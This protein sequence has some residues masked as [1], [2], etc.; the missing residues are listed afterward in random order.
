MPRQHP[1][2]GRGPA[3]HRLRVLR[4]RPSAADPPGADR[5]GGSPGRSARTLRD[6]R[7]FRNRPPA[8][9]GAGSLTRPG[10]SDCHGA[11]AGQPDRERPA[12]HAGRRNPQPRGPRRRGIVRAQAHRDRSARHGMRHPGVPSAPSV[13]ALLLDQERGYGSGSRSGAAGDRGARR[14]HR[15]GIAPGTGHPGDRHAAG[16]PRR[17]G[18]RAVSRRRGPAVAAVLM[19][20]AQALACEKETQRAARKAFQEILARDRQTA[21]QAAAL[22]TFVQDFPEPK[23]NPYLVRACS[24]LADYHARAGRAD[25]AASWYERAIRADPE[26]PDLLNSLGFHYARNGMNLDRAVSVLEEAVRLA[27]KR[28]L[29]SRRQGFIKDSLGWAYRMRGDLP[30]AVALLEESSRLAPGTPIIRQHLAD[31]YHAIG[32]RDKAVS[33]DLEL[34]LAGRGTDVTLRNSLRAM[35]HEGGPAYSRQVDRRIA[36]GLRALADCDRKAAGSAG[37]TLVHL[38]AGDGQRLLGSLFPPR[39][40]P[41]RPGDTSP[42]RRAAV[43]LL[44]PLGSNRAACAATAGAI[45]AHGLYALTLDLRRHAR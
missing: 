14:D 16:C 25:I 13:R 44:H 45:G 9:G 22:E 6:R 34:Y 15:P 20:V 29:A 4:L 36:A 1:E 17:R 26:D 23:T 18:R 21:E 31:A 8:R 43:L 33:V 19:L 35:G 37:A 39:E 3:G 5:S 32:E 27:E 11:G 10:R 2:A 40:R 41:V 7:A 30:L 24:M 28:R 38:T 42:G 12:G